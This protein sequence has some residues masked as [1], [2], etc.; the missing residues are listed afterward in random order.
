MILQ[1]RQRDYRRN[2]IVSMILLMGTFGMTAL[3]AAADPVDETVKIA[4]EFLQVFCAKDMTKVATY[5]APGARVQRARLEGATPVVETFD[6]AAWVAEAGPSIADLQDFKIEILEDSGL[7]FGEGT[8]V[9]G[10]TV[11]VRFRATGAV[12]GGSFVNNGVDTF[13]FAKIDGAWRIVLY[14]SY[15]KLI[16]NKP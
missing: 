3:P 6:A 16:F 14:N 5:F 7:D 4:R 15:E 10:T 11:S 8:T 2:W 12:G 13:S 1:H 9:E